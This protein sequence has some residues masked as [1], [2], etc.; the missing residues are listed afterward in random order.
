MN[1]LSIPILTVALSNLI[2]LF[3][4][5]LPVKHAFIN[6]IHTVHCQ[7]DELIIVLSLLIPAMYSLITALLL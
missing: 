5:F 6:S 7:I 1:L 4:P 3:A 2:P